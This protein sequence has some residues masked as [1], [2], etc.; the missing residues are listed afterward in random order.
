[1]TTL[2]K[3]QPPWDHEAGRQ[4]MA[5]AGTSGREAVMT[6]YVSLVMAVAVTASAHAGFTELND[7]SNGYG[8]ELARPWSTTV[9]A[10]ASLAEVP[11]DLLFESVPVPTIEPSETFELNLRSSGRNPDQSPAPPT[12]SSS[13]PGRFIFGHGGDTG[14]PSGWWDFPSGADEPNDPLHMPLP[15]GAALGLL[16]LAAVFFLRR[17]GTG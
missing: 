11:V 13:L 6:R 15:P 10:E 5:W 17:F 3:P 1:M 4:G 2:G 9:T 14:G 12:P 16:G 8:G 7:P